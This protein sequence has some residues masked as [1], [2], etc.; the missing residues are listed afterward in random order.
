MNEFTPLKKKSDRLHNSLRAS[1][2]H[3]REGNDQLGWDNFQNSMED[4]ENLLEFEQ[5]FEDSKCDIQK[6]TTGL[7]SLY[8]CMQNKDVIG[9]TDVLEFT[10]YPLTNQ[11]VIERDEK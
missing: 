9:M 11:R 7:Q 1:I 2:Q 5:Y 6:I 8:V 10:L 4:L 3:F